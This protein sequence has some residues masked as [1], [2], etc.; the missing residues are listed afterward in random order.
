MSE[1]SKKNYEEN[2]NNNNN[3]EKTNEKETPNLSNNNNNNNDKNIK[4]EP[5]I[6]KKFIDE[7][8]LKELEKIEQEY[9]TRLPYPGRKYQE[10]DNLV[11]CYKCKTLNLVHE[12]WD[13][14][15]C[16]NCHTYCKIP[17]ERE[18]DNILSLNNND[19][20]KETLSKRVP[21]L[22]TLLV[23][24]KCK[25]NNRVLIT[26]TKMKCP[27]CLE[28]F[29]I[30]KPD[31]NP[32]KELCESLDPN[33]HY[34]KF[35]YKEIDPIYPPKNVIG[36]NDLYFPDPYL[37]NNNY[38]IPFPL[39]PFINYTKPYQDF[40]NAEN[41]KKRLIY[42]GNLKNRL[43][44]NMK[45]YDKKFLFDK[46]NE[47][48]NKMDKVIEL[49]QYKGY[50]NNNNNYNKNNYDNY[51]NNFQNN[52]SLSLNNIN[53][54]LNKYNNYIGNRENKSKLVQN[55]FFLNNK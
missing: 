20:N 16:A 15:E 27:C 35:K 37:F 29:T 34:Y 36:I 17:K 13:F 6:K 21:C 7:K 10:G 49:N 24:P 51:Y 25:K 9:K 3:N 4:T 53:Y 31:R 14:I 11:I 45:S 1:T 40:V 32:P 44:I 2:N 50:Y 38:Q 48:G 23:C 33:S 22:Y 28:T 26:E 46:L 5:E 30:L 55:I 52:R 8:F 42:Y 54:N 47:L 18:N 12:T 39:N 41:A 43:K 19:Y